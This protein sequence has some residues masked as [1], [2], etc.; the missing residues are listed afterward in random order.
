MSEP[1]TAA[2]CQRICDHMNADHSEDLVLYVKAFG[3]PQN[4]TTAKLVALDPE[5]MDL[6]AQVPAGTV[7]LRIQFDHVLQDA[8]DAHYTLVTLSKEARKFPA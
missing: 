7:S 6:V 5:G 2:I 4:L 3:G 1:L 8:A